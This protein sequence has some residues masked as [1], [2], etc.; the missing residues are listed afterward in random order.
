[1]TH[2]KGDGPPRRGHRLHFIAVPHWGPSNV[3]A[4][5][6]DD[7]RMRLESFHNL[8]SRMVKFHAAPGTMSMRGKRLDDPAFRPLFR[9][10]IARGMAIMTH[11]G[12]PQTWYDAKYNDPAKYFGTRDDHYRMWESLLEEYRGVRG[13]ARTWVATRRPAPLQD[14]L[15]R[16]PVCGWIAAPR[17]GWSARS[18][19]GATPPATFSS[20]TR[21]A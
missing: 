12:D 6:F 17:G 14:L 21:T 7:Y 15:D 8:G 2:W 18:A 3:P 16:F 4:D 20:A 10:A 9:E 19:Q 11:V 5:W 1:M 13:S